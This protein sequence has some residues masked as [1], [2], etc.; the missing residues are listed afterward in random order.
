MF[1]R[2]RLGI[3]SFALPLVHMRR[4][5]VARLVVA[6]FC[7]ANWS[8]V[9]ADDYG[10]R[11]LLC[12]SNPSGPMAE[13]ECRPPI[14]RMLREQRQRRPPPF[15]TCE[16]ANGAAYVELGASAFDPCPDGT[17]ALAVG[18]TATWGRREPASGEVQAIGPRAIVFTGIGE[19]DTD[20]GSTTVGMKKICVGPYVGKV[21]VTSGVGDASSSV[22]IDAYEFIATL[23][24]VTD[25]PR[26]LDVIVQGKRY[27]R[28]RY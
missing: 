5:V 22:E 7:G 28:I 25:T 1:C 8:A 27:R 16:E 23:D 4:V 14:E 24:P 11:V 21:G 17:L 13:A 15:P 9:H 20:G 2:S 3:F 12:L 26:Y 18:A 6:W 19:G 10:C